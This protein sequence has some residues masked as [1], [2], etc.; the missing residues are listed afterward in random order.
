M[1][2]RRKCSD[3]G[4]MYEYEL[5]HCP[6]CKAPECFSDVIPYDMRDWIYDIE[7]YPNVFTASF[8]HA[9][10]GIRQ[11][12][13]ITP[14]VNQLPHLCQFLSMLAKNGC[15]LVGFNNV[16][17]DY[18]VIHYIMQQS[19][20]VNVESIYQ[21]AASII[22]SDFNDYSHIIWDSEV[23][24]PQ[25]DL[26][27]IHHFD[28]KSRRTGLKMLEFNMC[29]DDIEDLPYEAGLPLTEDQVPSLMY[30][31]D[32]DV[33]ETFKFYRKSIDQIE[34]REQL[35]NK[36]ERNFMNHNDTKIGKDYFIMELERLIPGSCYDYSTGRKQVRQTPR[37]IVQI[38]DVVFPYVRFE[39]HGFNLI[40]QWL[41]NFSIAET[42]GVFEY[43]DVT[44]EMAWY[45]NPALIK[46]HNLTVADVPHLKDVT[47]IQGKLLKGLPLKECKEQLQDRSDLHRFRFVS[48]CKDQSGLNVI[49]QGFR[50]DFGTGGIHGS[51]ESQTVH[52]DETHVI[53]DWDVASYYPNLAIA[54]RLYPEHLSEQFCN[55][56][57]D[58]YNQRKQ[59]K[60]GTAENAMLKLALNGVYGDSNNQYSP[61]Y[62]W[63][64]T[65]QVT[66]NGQ[67][68]LCMLAE[69]LINIPN[70]EMVQIN[71]DGLTVR[72]P[73][74]YVD[75]MK[76]VC[77]WWEDYTCLEL[78]SAIYEKMFIRDVNNYVALYENGDVKRK[79]AYEYKLDWH[80]NFSA[81][82]IPKAVEAHLIHGVPVE[83][84]IMNHCNIH[85]FMYR[86]KINRSD[87]LMYGEE[88]LQR[89]TRYYISNTGDKLVKVSPPVKGVEVGQWKRKNGI[90]DAFYTQVL[91]EISGGDDLDSTGKPWDE[92]INTK[93]KSRYEIRRTDIQSG[94]T[95]TPCN[96]ITTA[97]YGDIDFE[98]YVGQA[99]KLI[100]PLR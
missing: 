42:K 64:Y 52:S 56:Y 62:D 84:F 3:C 67:L 24:I 35:S 85:D 58:V 100:N 81:L 27:K 1:L 80:Q 74:E 94:C 32:H 19:V 45:M 83:Q 95:V 21:K 63:F 36:Y 38:N 14:W 41:K 90:S 72:C 8:L 4:S 77:K 54:N 66:I 37:D 70:L 89:I 31:N 65:M 39:Q 79:G 86:T 50:Y 10:C 96:D 78:E 53:Y 82:V 30:Y 68:L 15:R 73:R 43:L 55:I 6:K 98:Y 5:T 88:K 60:K 25:L 17:F 26:Y 69:Q 71:T 28:N 87:S 11:R 22:D 76:T 12:F 47:N 7:T 48:G 92:R 44:P 57:L 59:H 46:V 18:P 29:S 51:V 49:I 99:L 93:N 13:Q 97:N 61:F 91:G 34:F 2:G 16:G 40:L 9:A 75:H 20:Y 33:D 23:I